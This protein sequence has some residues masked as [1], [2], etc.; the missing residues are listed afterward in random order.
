MMERNQQL[1]CLR[2]HYR[3]KALADEHLDWKLEMERKRRAGGSS[4]VGGRRNRTARQACP[5][6]MQI[7]RTFACRSRPGSSFSL[8]K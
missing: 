7:P 1:L 4:V 6:V 3:N 2:Q 5:E 8:S